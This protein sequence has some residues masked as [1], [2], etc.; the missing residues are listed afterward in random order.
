MGRSL[1]D[2]VAEERAFQLRLARL[3]PEPVARDRV[4][5]AV[6]AEHPARLRQRPGGKGVRAVALM[7][8]GQRRRVIGIAQVEIKPLERRRGEQP[9]VNDGAARKARDVEILDALALGL[10]LDLVAAEEQFALELVVA[11]HRGV[12][13]PDQDLLDVGTG[14][15]RLLPEHRPVHRHRAPAENEKLVLAQHDL[16]DVP[17]A[18]LRVGVVRQE[19]HPHA[20]VGIL[21]KL[22]AH[23][24]DL[25]P[26]KL[27]RNLGQHAR[28]VAGLRVGVHCAAMNQRADAGQRLAQDRIGTDPLDAGD[29]AHPAG[30]VFKCRIVES[31]EGFRAVED[32]LIKRHWVKSLERR[33]KVTSDNFKYT[34]FFPVRTKSHLSHSSYPSHS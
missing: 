23:L 13:P 31:V 28:A 5:L 20:E 19:H 4:D 6:V 15:Q 14:A 27:V 10:V 21:E 9:L 30:V 26:E 7:E 32:G 12:G 11:H 25:G 16:R 8:D 1:R 33:F 34:P 17:A 24:L 22:V 2:R 3:R 18:R 29:H